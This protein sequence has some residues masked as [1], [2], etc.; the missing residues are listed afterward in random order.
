MELVQ[1]AFRDGVLTE[2]ATWQAVVLIPKGGGNYCGRVLVGMVWK[3]VKVILNHRFTTSIT[4]HN[5]IHG[6]WLGCGTGTAP[7]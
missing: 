2:E 6:F 4:Y 3:V 1:K 5:S 7:L